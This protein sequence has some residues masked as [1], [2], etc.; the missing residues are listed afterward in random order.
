MT[1]LSLTISSSSFGGKLDAAA[2]LNYRLFCR[3]RGMVGS[4]FDL[5]RFFLAFT[6]GSE[7]DE[8]RYGSFRK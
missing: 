3:V 4:G 2:L 5:D 7:V 6:V 1:N 8:E